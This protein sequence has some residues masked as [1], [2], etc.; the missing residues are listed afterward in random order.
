MLIETERLILRPI[1]EGDAAAMVALLSDDEA[2]V[3]MTEQLPWPMTASGARDWIALRQEPGEHVY[4]ITLRSSAECI[5]CVGYR[6]DGD[7]AVLGY[8]MGSAYRN[9]GYVTEA[10]RALLDHARR[11]GVETVLGETFVDNAASQ[12]VLTKLDFQR[13]GLLEKSVATR[14]GPR[15]VQRFARRL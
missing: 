12:H 15:T 3:R 14:E 7:Q 8:W 10:I 1:A 4:A 9:K 2:G 5:G 11:Q 6:R 13:V